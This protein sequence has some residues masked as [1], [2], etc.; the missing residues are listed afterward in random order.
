MK[1]GLPG[2][3]LIK[4]FEGLRLKAYLCSANVVTIGWGHTKTAKIGQ[5]ITKVRAQELFNQDIEF[6][7][8]EVNN[9][10]KV[11][12]SQNLFD[13]LVSFAY[14]CGAANLKK[15]TLLKK[16]NSRAPWAELLPQ[17]NRWVFG[18]GKRL[19]GLVRRRQAEAL[20]AGGM[21]WKTS[22]TQTDAEERNNVLDE[23]NGVVEAEWLR[24]ET[25][26]ATPSKNTTVVGSTAAIVLALGNEV[27]TNPALA[28]STLK[29]SA[30]ELGSYVQYVPVISYGIT[31]LMVGSLGFVI[32]TR[33]KK[34]IDSK[35]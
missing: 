17:F 30:D 33:V 8:R 7:V 5:T 14:N 21:P 31:A 32:Y 6:F 35:F 27:V 18:G 9:L 29:D 22:A 26:A 4:H 15:S 20:L 34:L 23:S 2:E 13:A 25:N 3:E 16:V 1:L 11:D 10:V 28:A 19:T 12:I 24:H